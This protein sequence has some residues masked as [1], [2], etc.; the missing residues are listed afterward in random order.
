[1]RKQGCLHGARRIKVAIKRQ[2]PK[3]H[4]SMGRF[5]MRIH[6]GCVFHPSEEAGTKAQVRARISFLSRKQA[7]KNDTKTCISAWFYVSVVTV[8]QLVESRIVIP[9]V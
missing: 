3:E 5:G 6:P 4:F 8:A 7:Q 1:M 9:V 2:A